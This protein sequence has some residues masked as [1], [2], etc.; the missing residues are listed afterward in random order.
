MSTV[1]PRSIN[2]QRR[3]EGD[4]E[5]SRK[6]KAINLIGNFSFFG[7]YILLFKR[8]LS[9]IDHSW[10]SLS[11]HLPFAAQL[12]GIIPD[13]NFIQIDFFEKRF[14][15]FPILVEYLQGLLWQLT[16]LASS[17][18][19][20]NL[21][22]L[23]ILNLYLAYEFRKAFWRV[24]AS[25]L[26]IPLVL[27][28]STSAY[29]DLFPSCLISISILLSLSSLYSKTPFGFK[30][31]F[32][33]VFTAALASFSKYQML[34]ISCASVAVASLLFWATLY[35]NSDISKKTLYMGLLLSFLAPFIILGVPIKNYIHYNDPVYPFGSPSKAPQPEI[36]HRQDD[37]QVSQS[38][39]E[40][41]VF[42]K[43][44]VRFFKSLSEYDL[45][46]DGRQTLFS[47]DQSSPNATVKSHK[48]GGFFIANLLLWICSLIAMFSVIS[49][50]RKYW[51]ALANLLCLL[52]VLVCPY[53]YLL[54][55]WLFLPIVLVA[56]IFL[57]EREHCEKTLQIQK[58]NSLLQFAIF[59]IV[60]RLCETYIFGSHANPNIDQFKL[61]KI[62][63]NEAC[64]VAPE[65]EA[66]FYMLA[67]KGRKFQFVESK[68]TCNFKPQPLSK[69]LY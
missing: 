54:R 20:V 25:L 15:G 55:Y 2:S 34:P 13:E 47:I 3:P 50:L 9:G 21:I 31:F 23:L 22:A 52:V 44:S 60:V 67:N 51:I 4:E 61:P 33:V 65:R 35:K 39:V 29:N 41:G 8:A 18:N 14:H 19:L 24:A 32:F 43:N 56:S 63:N 26:S 36:R 12:G 45:Y 64:L 53:P 17:T 57:L 1:E 5:T 58:L 66:M 69:K 68:E 27:I 30:R 37:L 28:H 10:D 7:I 48:I 62:S 38:L 40:P 49:G 42:L 46:T 16:G 6:G 59:I 11:Y